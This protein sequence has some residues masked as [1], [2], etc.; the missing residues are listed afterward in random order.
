MDVAVNPRTGQPHDMYVIENPRWVNMV[1]LT[2]NDEVILVEQ[3]RHGTRSVQLETPG[4]LMDEGET[5]LECAGRELLEETGYQAETIVPLGTVHPNPAI[6]N[7]Q[8]DYVLAANCRKVAEPSLDAA[9]DIHV[10][11]VPLAKIPSM[12][13]S[14]EIT[15]ALVINAFYLLDLYRQGNHGRAG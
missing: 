3:W 15:H 2:P 9:E 12:I 8:L 14:G 10:R 13:R 4:G 11:L 6:Q 1:P 7:N 5:A